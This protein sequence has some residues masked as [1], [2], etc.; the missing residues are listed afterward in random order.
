MAISAMA[1]RLAAIIITLWLFF[2]LL[3]VFV[4]LAFSPMGLRLLLPDRHPVSWVYPALLIVPPVA[5]ASQS[6]LS[7]R[8]SRLSLWIIVIPLGAFTLL[9]LAFFGSA[10]F[11]H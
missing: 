9:L 10:F 3:S 5:L 6:L 7:A 4:A 1:N 2:A 11:A 8:F